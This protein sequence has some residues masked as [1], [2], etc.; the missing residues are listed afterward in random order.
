MADFVSPGRA[1]HRGTET[2]RAHRGVLLCA[3]AAS[4]CLCDCCSWPLPVAAAVEALE[5]VAHGV[6][7]GVGHVRRDLL[8]GAEGLSVLVLGLALGVGDGEVP[9]VAAE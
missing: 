2:Q 5:G 8:P 6:G 7:V 4:L 3:P 1:T 9:G